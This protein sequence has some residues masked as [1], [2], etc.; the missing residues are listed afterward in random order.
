MR[1]G[2]N[3]RRIFLTSGKTPE[4]P[5]MFWR[6]LARFEKA[7]FHTPKM[8]SLMKHNPTLPH[9]IPE[10]SEA[11]ISDYAFHLYEQSR[12]APGHDLEN[13]LEASACL[14]ANIPTHRSGSR[15]HW[16]VNQPASG[17]DHSVSSDASSLGS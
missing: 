12:C 2:V 16:H 5:T 7:S 10:P 4:S 13:W 14:K 6:T 15:L 8:L 17:E 11:E 9:S 3:R 1:I